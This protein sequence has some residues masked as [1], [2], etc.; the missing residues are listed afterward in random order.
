MH[1]PPHVKKQLE[2]N[3]LIMNISSL[4]GKENTKPKKPSLTKRLPTTLRG[5]KWLFDRL[6]LG[7]IFFVGVNLNFM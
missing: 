6:D 1:I 2:A 4:L 7:S 3:N 5:I